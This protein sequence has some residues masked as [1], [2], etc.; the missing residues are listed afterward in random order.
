MLFLA[1]VTRVY[2]NIYSFTL[3][4]YIVCLLHGDRMC[5]YEFDERRGK[6]QFYLYSIRFFRA[7]HI[8]GARFLLCE[9]FFYSF[10]LLCSVLFCAFDICLRASHSPLYNKI[11]VCTLF[12]ALCF[13]EFNVTNWKCIKRIQRSILTAS[14]FAERLGRI[15]SATETKSY[16]KHFFLLC[17]LFAFVH[18]SKVNISTL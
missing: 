5:V 16:G 11:R 2:Q 4:V 15:I 12:C 18:L 8:L 17:L 14:V 1:R 13:V 3:D 7:F 9:C 6:K 10:Y